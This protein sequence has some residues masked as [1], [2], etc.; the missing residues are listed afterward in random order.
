MRIRVLSKPPL[1]SIRAWFPIPDH[2]AADAVSSSTSVPMESVWDLK[3]ALCDGIHSLPPNPESLVLMIDG[4][5]L[6]DGSG[7][8]VVKD[9][10]LVTYVSLS[11]PL[12]S[13]HLH[14]PSKEG[15]SG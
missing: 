13:M 8:D 2:N 12:C 14:Y 15:P 9:G 1:P 7:L 6:L 11:R 5:E 4:F 10:D 3:R